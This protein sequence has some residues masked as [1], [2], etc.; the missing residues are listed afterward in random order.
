MQLSALS[1]AE[2]PNFCMIAREGE[3]WRA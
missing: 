3:A 1:V 2:K